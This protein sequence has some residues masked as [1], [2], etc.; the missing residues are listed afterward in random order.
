[1]ETIGSHT[2]W[3]GRSSTGL[4]RI[5]ATE[6]IQINKFARRH[7]IRFHRQFFLE[8]HKARSLDR[9]CFS[10]TLPT[11]CSSLNIISHLMHM[12]TTPR[13]TVTVSRLTLAVLYSRC[14]SALQ[15]CRGYG[16][17]HGDSHGYGYGMDMG[18]MM[19]PHGSVGI[20]W[21][22]LNGFRIT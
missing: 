19:N 18:T 14:L 3:A 10:F 5:S 9:S 7:Q 6:S 4:R 16:D 22:F 2:V 12:Q 20:P 8:C 21:G 1:M 15:G 17:S 11:C 13:F